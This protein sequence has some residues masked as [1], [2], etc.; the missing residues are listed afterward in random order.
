MEVTRRRKPVAGVVADAAY[1]CGA[2]VD[3]PRDLPSGRLH[4]PLDR[5]P[6]AL[7]A[8]RVELLGLRASE[9]G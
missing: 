6:E 2:F 4:Q 3:E 9:S 8:E 5:D 7:G 1:D